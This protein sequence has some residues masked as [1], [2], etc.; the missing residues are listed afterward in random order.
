MAININNYVDI[1]ATFPNAGASG[2]AFGGMVFTG[3]TMTEPTS[4]WD[5]YE[6]YK[7]IFDAYNQYLPVKLT[8]AQIYKLFPT[9]GTEPDPTKSDYVPSLQAEFAETYYGYMSPSGR[10]ASALS[11]VKYDPSKE[12]MV[13]NFRALNEKT[14]MFGSFTFLDLPGGDESSDAEPIALADLVAVA[15]EN[16][17]LHSKYLF[18]VNRVRGNQDADTVVADIQ[19]FQAETNGEKLHGTCFVSGARDT[20]ASMPMAIFAATDYNDGQVTNFMFKQFTDDEVS[21]TSDTDYRAFTVANVNFYGQTQTNGQTLN[22]YQRGFNTD[23]METSVYCNEVWLKSICET[24]LLNMLIEH[25]RISA[26]LTGVSFA[27]LE[28]LECCGRGVSNGMFMT[29]QLTKSDL[30]EIRNY[31]TEAGGDSAMVDSIEADI[32]TKGYSIYAFLRDSNGDTLGDKLS[33]NGEKYIAY[34]L[35]YGTADSIRYIKGSDI[36]IK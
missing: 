1:S 5:D 21:V 29:K 20:S 34:L 35:F 10:A 18:V 24:A 25:D 4:D 33:A 7:A 31:I 16:S 8:L 9:K 30:K 12:G 15:K 27:K 23:G 6:S 11:F 2:R 26:D 19:A 14:N 17:G 3:S 13:G 28:L 22:F 36:L 32:G